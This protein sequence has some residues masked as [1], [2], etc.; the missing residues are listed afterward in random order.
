MRWNKRFCVYLVLSWTALS[1]AVQAASTNTAAI[2]SGTAAALPSCLNW[3]LDGTCLWLRCGW[4]G[5]R[6]RTTLRVYNYTPEA[7]VTVR[8]DSA[9]HP[10]AEMTPVTATSSGVLLGLTA[11]LADGNGNAGPA[12][13]VHRDRRNLVYREADVIGH[14][15]SAT[16]FTGLAQIGAPVCLPRTI[17][18]FPYFQ[19]GN[20]ALVW[21]DITPVESLYPA[22][23]LPGLREIGN[24][25]LNTWGSVYPRTGTVIQQEEPKAAAVIAQRAA[26]I[27]SRSAQPHVYVPLTTGMASHG[28]RWWDPEPLDERDPATGTWQMLKP[29]LDTGCYVFGENDSLSLTSWSDGR[30]DTEGDYVFNLWRPYSCCR[31]AGIFIGSIPGAAGSLVGVGT[32]IAFGDITSTVDGLTD[33]IGDSA[34]GAVED[35]VTSIVSS[36]VA[37][38]LITLTDD[39]A[40]DNTRPV[41][42]EW[43]LP[44]ARADGEALDLY[45][46]ISG[47]TLY[48]GPDADNLRRIAEV[49]YMVGEPETYITSATLELDTN[50][51]VFA[52]TAYDIWGNE[53]ER[54]NVLGI[55]R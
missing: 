23:L 32:D 30:M 36:A 35:S 44:E 42:V 11:G 14:P 55:E 51:R 18:L 39:A 37:E 49:S 26:D 7:V 48:G 46:D 3:R 1:G 53:S 27:A 2:I 24:F 54:S 43:A 9:S 15:L 21:R 5:C 41:T 50:L 28:N 16:R 19:S 38:A 22:A 40:G 10:W 13:Q 47:V 12:G 4:G 34:G 31:S 17:P 29:R 45:H 33:A 6:V 52:M 20:D 8:N 25:P